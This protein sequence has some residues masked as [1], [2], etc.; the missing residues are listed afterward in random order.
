MQTNNYGVELMVPLQEDKEIIFNEALIVL[1]SFCNY[2]ITDFI[3][4]IPSSLG[5]NEKYIITSGIHK[6]YICFRPHDNKLIK[7]LKPKDGMIIFIRKRKDFLK[8]EKAAPVK[9][10]LSLLLRPLIQNLM[11]LSARCRAIEIS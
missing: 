1:D 5:L 2:M 9:G 8:H 7:I 4:V 10:R 11:R 3:E 6:N